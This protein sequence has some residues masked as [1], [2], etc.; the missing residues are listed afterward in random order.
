MREACR[1]AA[2]W[3]DIGVSVNVSPVQFRD[4]SLVD[5]VRS[6][7]ADAG[8]P[9]HRLEIEVTEGVLVEDAARARLLLDELKALGV[10][11]AIDDF[12]TGYA[13]LSDLRDYPFDVIKIDRQFIADIDAREGGRAVVQAILGLGKAL[14]LSVTAQGVE[15]TGQLAWLIR[16]QCSEVQG[17]LLARPMA[18]AKVADMVAEHGAA[19]PHGLPAP[20]PVDLDDQRQSKRSWTGKRPWSETLHRPPRRSLWRSR[21]E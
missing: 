10:T 3:G 19:T 21:Y 14:G 2:Q 16:D 18:A 6:A 11:L 1:T 12:G 7:L 8:L 5:M 9:A 17:Y 15:T 4:D 20:P 13:S